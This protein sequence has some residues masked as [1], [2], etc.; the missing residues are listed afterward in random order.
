MHQNGA[1]KISVM[2]ARLTDRLEHRFCKAMVIG[3]IPISNNIVD[4]V[5]QIGVGFTITWIYT[6]GDS[7]DSP[8]NTILE[9]NIRLIEL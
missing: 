1:R 7:I 9:F 5:F 2:W 8:S 6:F 3:S 4:K